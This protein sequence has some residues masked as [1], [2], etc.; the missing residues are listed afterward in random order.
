MA[1]STVTHRGLTEAEVADSRRL[2][3]TNRLT[4]AKKKSL[5]R[6]F[7]DNFND[8]IIRV[9]LIALALNVA[10]SF[11]HVNWFETAGICLAIFLSTLVST[12]S[13]Y[14]SERAFERLSSDLADQCT[15]V[16]RDGQTREISI[17]SLVRGDVAIL[18]A[19]ETVPADCRILSGAVSVD[20]SALSGESAELHKQAG[21]GAFTSDLSAEHLL[22][23][24]SLLLSGSA[25]VEV[26]AVGD[27]TLYGS[28]VG[29]VQTETRESPLRLRLGHL[30]RQISRI[31]YV[32]A[33]LVAF[34]YLYVTLF[35]GTGLGL[36]GLSSVFSNPSVLFPALLHAFTLAVTVVVVAVPEGLPMMITVVL[37]RNMK[38]M[39]KDNVLVKKL[40]GIETAGS[41]NVLFSDKTGT[42]TY[43]KMSQHCVLL[44]D[45]SRIVGAG[46]LKKQETLCDLLRYNAFYNTDAYLA[47]GKAVGGNATDRA[48]LAF[49]SG[50]EKPS[51]IPRSHLPFSS[52]TRFEATA[53]ASPDL[54]LIKGAPEVLLPLCVRYLNREGTYSQIDRDGMTACIA[55][56]KEATGRGERVLAVCTS[57]TWGSEI[58]AFSRLTLVALICLKDRVRPDAKAAVERL[59]EA[60][61][62]VVMITGDNPD[63]ACSV[64]AECG[65]Y[66]PHTSHLALTG[67]EMATLSDEEL[68]AL[69]PRVRVVARALPGDK[70]RLVRLCQAQGLVVGM[71]GD[72]INDAPSLKLADVG[73]SMGEGTA[74]AK[75]ASDIVLLDGHIASVGNTVLYGRTI[76]R[77]I[78]KFITFQLMMNLCAV[79][80]SLLGQYV[81]IESP[82]TIIQ[83]LWINMIMDTLGGLAFAGEAPLESDMRE[84]PKRR[85]EP[86]LCGSML[87]RIL[88][89]GGATLMLCGLFL[90]TDYFRL[91]FGYHRDPVAFLTSFFVLFVISGIY[92][93]FHVRTDRINPF[94]RLSKNPLFVGIMAFIA[95]VQMLIVYKGGTVFRTVPLPPRA[96]LALLG[97]ALLVTLADLV[98]KIAYRLRRRRRTPSGSSASVAASPLLKKF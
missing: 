28:I 76:F 40:V 61:I 66:L 18:S 95:V 9:L 20:Q 15:H 43:G 89:T 39:L 53:L 87:Y 30:A 62:R 37:A 65:I 12:L 96:M 25:T 83:M 93:C 47:E 52:A 55:E 58:T 54:T 13:E 50:E 4:R 42:L 46:A 68:S 67:A 81:G 70:T 29:G 63:T 64:A 45:G 31:G 59:K 41:M 17:D 94:S 3:G 33:A 49:F 5:P 90:G 1:A 44:G 22:F 2:Y 36:A 74:V 7:L 48:L 69:L 27:S 10:L 38:R 60:G 26:C 97:Y 78:R 91:R 16:L 24:G 14:G 84:P 73:F 8:P 86:I 75:E 6:R 56:W 35:A 57:P 98:G 71:T 82:V 77:S 79:G 34:A 32:A 23:R 19:G 11:G 51:A 80:V 21:K 72:G 88:F 92:N 85:D